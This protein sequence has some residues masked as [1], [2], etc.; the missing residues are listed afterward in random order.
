MTKLEDQYVVVAQVGAPRGVRG[1]LKLRS[2]TESPGEVLAFNQFFLA[3][4]DGWQ[5]VPGLKVQ[6]LG[7]G[8]C[9]YFP[10]CD[11]RDQARQYVNR[12]LAVRREQLPALT[13]EQYYWADLEGL[14]VV[15]SD[16]SC[17]GTVSHLFSTAGNDVLVVKG[18]RERLIPF[19]DSVILAVDFD[20]NKVVVDWELEF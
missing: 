3:Q 6:A 5:P 8:F 4:A 20:A 19:I 18:E 14:S 11:D 9:V 12:T 10:G 15:L 7:N 17:L 2:F 16:G 1:W 13:D